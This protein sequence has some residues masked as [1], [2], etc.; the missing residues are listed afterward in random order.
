MLFYGILVAYAIMAAQRGA[1]SAER[2]L[3]AM[4][5]RCSVALLSNCPTVPEIRLLAYRRMGVVGPQPIAPVSVVPNHKCPFIYPAPSV[6]IPRPHTFQDRHVSIWPAPLLARDHQSS[7][8]CDY[9]FVRQSTQLLLF[10]DRGCFLH[11]LLCP[12]Y[13]QLYDVS[14]PRGAQLGSA[15]R[16]L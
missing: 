11:G 3:L 10:G 16:C 12:P 1:E 14:H 2:C 13:F 6:L 8:R 4:I 5:R 9:A 7:A 15:Y